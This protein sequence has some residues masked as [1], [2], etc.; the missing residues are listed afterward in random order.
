M[1]SW[2]K[3]QTLACTDIVQHGLLY[4]NQCRAQAIIPL[5]VSLHM[6]SVTVCYN[7]AVVEVEARFYIWVLD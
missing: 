2:L 3:V 5:L 1:N 7:E 6:V 4:C